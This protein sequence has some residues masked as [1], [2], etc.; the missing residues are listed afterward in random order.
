MLDSE[1]VTLKSHCLKAKLRGFQIANATE[2]AKK[3]SSEAGVQTP[4]N[5]S[6]QNLLNLIALVEIKRK[7]PSLAAP[8]TNCHEDVVLQQP[9]LAV[10]TTTIDAPYPDE[11]EGEDV[12]TGLAPTPLVPET[13]KVAQTKPTVAKRGRPKKS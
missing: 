10:L 6:P 13:K 5:V 1:L 12:F 2:M 7:A 11:D 9:A 8:I 4:W 3:L